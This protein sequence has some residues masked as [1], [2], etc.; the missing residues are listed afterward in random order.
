MLCRCF[1]DALQMLCRCFA[2][3]GTKRGRK[4]GRE[5][6]EITK[7][8]KLINSIKFSSSR[9]GNTRTNKINIKY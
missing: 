6:T 3:K 4:L 1:A 7:R 9:K 5:R 8:R 2:D